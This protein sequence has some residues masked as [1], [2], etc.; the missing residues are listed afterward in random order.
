MKPAPSVLRVVRLGAILSLL[1]AA[2]AGLPVAAADASG[3][4]TGRVTNEATG[5]VL[6]NVVVTVEGTNARVTTDL[7]GTFRVALPS[8]VSQLVVSYPGLDEQR[9]DLTV[10]A[11]QT[12]V[13][14]VA[15][16]SAA[17]KME[18]YVVKGLR[19]GQAAAIQEEREAANVRTVA[20]IDAFGNPGAAIGEML[21]RLPGVS[22]DG[23]GGEVGAVYIRGMTQD[24]S[25]LLVDGS[26]IAV[27]GGTAISNGNVYFGQV[28][29]G[30]RAAPGEKNRRSRRSRL[31]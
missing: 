13:R 23:S 16:N 1:V 15:L 20:A 4:V 3:V 27:S 28:S 25:S 5:D 21:Q 17:Y 24:F 6:S 12:V 26:Q 22:V 31:S 8:G 19:E 11:G 29:T 2:G 30:R 14:D 7:N 10:A 9:I 18:R